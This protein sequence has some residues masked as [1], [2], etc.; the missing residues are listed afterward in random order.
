MIMMIIMFIL[1][2]TMF[3]FYPDGY[4]SLAETYGTALENYYLVDYSDNVWIVVYSS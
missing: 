4:L 1:T 3:K 2:V